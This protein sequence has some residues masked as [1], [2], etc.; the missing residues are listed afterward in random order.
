V[1]VV[2]VDGAHGSAGDARP[3]QHA[4]VRP[5]AIDEIKRYVD[6]RYVSA[7]EAFW[8]LFGFRMHAQWPPVERLEVHLPD[9]ER[10]YYREDADLRNVVP[11]RSKLQAW[12]DFNKEKAEAYDPAN[13][14]TEPHPCLSTT[15]QNF[16]SLA[17]WD[18]GKRANPA[19]GQEEVPRHWKPRVQGVCVGRMYHVMPTEGERFYL[20]LLLHHV[21]G[22]TS[23]EHLRTVDGHIYPTHKEACQARGL[24]E[25]D[26]EWQRCLEEAKAASSPHQFRSLF[27]AMLLYN[28]MNDPMGLWELFKEDL[29][30]DFKRQAG[31]EEFHQLH[32]DAALRALDVLLKEHNRSL[33]HFSLPVPSGSAPPPLIA[34]ELSKYNAAEQAQLLQEKVPLLNPQQRQAYDLIMQAVHEPAAAANNVFFIDG[35][36]GAGKTFLYSCILHDVRANGGIGLAVA[37]SGIAALL[38]EGGRTAHSRFKIPVAGLNEH[39]TCYVNRGSEIAELI[40]RC[41]VVIW[42]EAPMMSKHVFEAVDRT[43][44]DVMAQHN[45]A[46]EHKPFGGKVVVLGGDFRQILPVVRRGGAA[47]IIQASLNQ[48]ARIWPH[49]RVLK[50]HTNMRVLRLLQGTGDGAAAEATRLQEFADYLLR[51]GDGTEP[52]H[53]VGGVHMIR[54]PPEMVCPGDGIKDLIEDVFGELRNISDPAARAAFL[55]ERAILTPLN[56]DVDAINKMVSEAD[57][58]PPGQPVAERRTYISADSVMDPQQAG[59]YPTE[60]LNSLDFSGVPPHELHLQVGCPIILLRNLTSGLANGT[61]LIVKGFMD[62][63]LDAEVITGP[64]AGQRVLIPRLAIT[65]SD[66]D[67]WPFTLRRRQ[68]PVRSAFAMTINKSQGQTFKTVGLYLPKPVFTHGQLYVAFSRVGDGIG[69]RLLIPEA[70]LDDHG[71]TYTQNVVYAEVLLQNPPAA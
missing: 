35:V 64:S 21:P 32:F 20:R 59:Q 28:E 37:S 24:L 66:T 60:F 25:D 56:H 70:L 7:S 26:E 39:S 47:D 40:K 69:V 52:L 50:L 19:R 61:R 5:V 51:V 62:T 63:C 31:M 8:R 42:D 41:K 49:V 11:R 23:W 6:G 27:A 48:S 15:Y 44:R 30:E 33:D 65:P 57:M 45:A 16:P 1:A 38:L 34:Q 68:F 55:T 58:F 2:P 10:V 18:E 12:L 54:I 9:Q 17:V 13:P 3:A 14:E 22:A 43:F 46:L 29:A 71:G 4:A 36:G 67:N 53:D